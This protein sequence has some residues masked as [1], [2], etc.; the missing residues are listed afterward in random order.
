MLVIQQIHFVRRWLPWIVTLQV[1]VGK[2][3]GKPFGKDSPFWVTL[4]TFVIHG[5]EVIGSTLTGAWKKLIP[6]LMNDFKGFRASV[7]LQMWWKEQENWN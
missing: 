7:E 2:E 1:D 6:T 4:R 3:N 5:E